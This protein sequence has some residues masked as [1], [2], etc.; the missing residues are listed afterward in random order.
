MAEDVLA[1]ILQA[2]PGL[3]NWTFASYHDRRHSW[4]E[5][6]NGHPQESANFVLMEV[7]ESSNWLEL[8]KKLK[9]PFVKNIFGSIKDVP[10][11]NLVN[12]K[13]AYREGEVNHGHKTL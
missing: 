3:N 1:R 5:G 6:D 10:E 13:G 8:S 12:S 4:V 9:D 11:L 7:F 2:S